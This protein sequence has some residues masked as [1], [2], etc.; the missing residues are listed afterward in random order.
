MGCATCWRVTHNGTYEP[1]YLFN[2]D[3]CTL[4]YCCPECRTYWEIGEDGAVPI[5][6][7]EAGELAIGATLRG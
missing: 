4:L 6:D 2:A 5:S 7:A 3:R 1:P